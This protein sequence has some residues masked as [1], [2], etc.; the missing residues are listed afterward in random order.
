[1]STKFQA[2]A[3]VPQGGASRRQAKSQ[4]NSNDLNLKNLFWT[5]VIDIW[6]LF[7]IWGL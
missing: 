6:S 3:F 1:M 7:G 4:I 2:P 5:L